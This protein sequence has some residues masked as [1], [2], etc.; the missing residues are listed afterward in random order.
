MTLQ[1]ST[2][3]NILREEIFKS[4][5]QGHSI[6]VDFFRR[7]TKIMLFK[8]KKSAF[9][10]AEFGEFGEIGEKGNQ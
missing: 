10:T 1:S 5:V 4:R 2:K 7:K 8:K 6:H 3:H 9:K